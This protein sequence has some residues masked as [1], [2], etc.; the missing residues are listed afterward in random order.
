GDS[1]LLFQCVR[2]LAPRAGARS[3]RLRDDQ[4]SLMHPRAEC[5]MLSQ[6]AAELFKARR[7]QDICRPSL[8]PLPPDLFTPNAWKCALRS[9]RSGKAVPAG[10]PSIDTWKQDLDAAALELSRI[11][12]EALCAEGPYLPLE[13]TEMQFAW[14][15]KAGKTPSSPANLRSIGL[16]AA[17]TKGLLVILREAAKPAVLRYMFDSPQYAYRI[18]GFGNVAFVGG[19]MLSIDLRKA[20]DSVS[21][22]ELYGALLDAA[23]PQEVASVLIQ[24]HVQTQCVVM[25]GGA[26]ESNGMSRG[27]RQ[28]CPVS[29]IL[30]AAW[31]VRTLELFRAALREGSDRDCYTMFADD[32]HGC[33][34]FHSVADFHSALRDVRHVIQVLEGLGME[35]NLQK[36]LVVLRLR[37]S[38]VASATRHALV[39]HNDVQYLRLQ[40]EP[41]DLYIPVA[42]SMPYLGAT[43]SHENFE[44]QTLRTRTQCAQ[45][46]FQE[47]RK[48]LRSNGA[49]SSRHRLRLY[50][51]TVW[52]SLWYALGS[53][54]VTGEVLRGVISV[55]AGH[56]RNVLRVY[57]EGVTNQAVLLRADMCPRSFF[58]DQTRHKVQAILCDPLRSA[59]LKAREMNR[60]VTLSVAMAST[61]E[62]TSTSSSLVRV[63]PGD[64]V[65]LPCD[66]CGMYFGSREGLQMHISQQHPEINLSARL[67][68]NK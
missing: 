68:F 11:S 12:K 6:Y 42:T 52:P 34:E 14:L 65:S 20:F 23:V 13:W 43:L 28:G 29:P 53:T 33:W 39:W 25:H 9:L 40:S 48:V 3:I 19:M 24:I 57:Q 8:L 38:A 36:S 67:P 30:F 2:L 44:L 46:R 45:T 61:P 49:L 50:K 32:L 63:A 10:Q 62:A 7:A 60:A 41:K 58:I 4:G 27:L 17:D 5:R 18:L 21:H 66:V 16:M 47:L 56:L 31:S 15:P 1:R 26:S 55:V 59:A 35:L 54:G 51:A 64:A 22:A 37:G